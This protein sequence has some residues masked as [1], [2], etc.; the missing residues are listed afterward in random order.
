MRDRIL[1]AVVLCALLPT[2]AGAQDRGWVADVSIGLA[3]FIDDTTKTYVL[4]GGSVRRA[5]TPRVSIGPELVVMSNAN[6]VRD[7]NVLLTGNLVFDA[8]PDR[9]LSPFLVVG[10]GMFWGRDQ[11]AN[12]PF[13]SSEPAFTAG[14]GVRANL[15]EAV[16]AAVEYRLGWELHHRFSGSFGIRW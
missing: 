9:M 15:S 16:V 10:G 6:E 8:R 14:G 5:L 4:F 7:R 11:V 13:W 2:P 1:W 12:G 3:G